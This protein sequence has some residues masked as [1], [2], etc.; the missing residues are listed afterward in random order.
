M[1]QEEQPSKQDLLMSWQFPEYL[2]PERGKV[3]Y[4]WFFTIVVLLLVYSMV[5]INFLFA[6]I[7]IMGTIITLMRSKYHP[8]AVDFAITKDGLMV[9]GK[10]YA[11]DLIK[12]FYII[13]KPKE[14]KNLYFEFKSLVRP[15]IIIPLEDQNPLAV[16]DL[17]KQYLDENLEKE[18]EPA[19][20]AFRKLFKL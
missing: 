13:Y 6:I 1:E 17:L 18:E 9:E 11:Y 5:T 3:W 15:R 10:F 7:V 20:E 12:D 16:R 14:I 8:N 4:F 19:S 2:K